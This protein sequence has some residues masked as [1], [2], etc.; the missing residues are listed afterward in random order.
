VSTAPDKAD[1]FLAAFTP[2]HVANT[3]VESHK[4]AANLVH[5]VFM[6]VILKIKIFSLRMFPY[7]NDGIII[8]DLKINLNLIF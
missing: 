2:T 8:I 1:S 7:G 3:T 6:F 5:F 4:I